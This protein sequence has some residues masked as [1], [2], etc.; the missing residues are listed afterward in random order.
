MRACAGGIVTPPAAS[1]SAGRTSS[2]QGSRPQRRCSSPQPAGTPGTAT[3]A[4]PIA[5]TCGMPPKYTSTDT[6]GPGRRSPSVPGTATKKSRQVTSPV[7][8]SSQ[9]AN[10]PP[11]SPV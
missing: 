2:S 8:P 11:P 3:L 7:A 1:S 6:I 5:Y 9:V 10:P 4:P